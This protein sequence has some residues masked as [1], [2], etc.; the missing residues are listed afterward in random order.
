MIARSSRQCRLFGERLIVR[1]PEQSDIAIIARYFRE[2]EA[3]LAEFSPYPKEFRS[4]EF[5][6]LQVDLQQREFASDRSCK[7]FL[8][9]KNDATVIGSANLSEFVRGAFQAAYLGYT[10]AK[11]KQGQGLM[12]EAL[13][14]LIG[15]A[16]SDLRLHRIM[17]NYMLRNVRSGA[18]LERLGFT[19]E[20]VAR[21]YLL[22]NG[23]WEDHV[24]ASLTNPKWTAV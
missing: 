10:L 6:R 16:F 11:N 7:T 14:L 18:V 24:L 1:I 23:V 4:D 9:D 5:W 8:F 15:Y 17:A 20:G 13:S 3:H 12:Q 22:I 19:R 21:K 2:N